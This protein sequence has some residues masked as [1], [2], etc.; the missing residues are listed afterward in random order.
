MQNLQLLLPTKV[1]LHTKL[2][3]REQ[4]VMHAMIHTCFY[5]WRWQTKLEL[6]MIHRCFHFILISNKGF[7]VHTAHKKNTHLL[8]RPWKGAM[9]PVAIHSSIHHSQPSQPEVGFS[10]LLL[11]DGCNASIH[12]KS[13][14][15]SCSSIGKIMHI[16][17][18]IGV[19]GRLLKVIHLCY[20]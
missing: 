19:F 3:L 20:A 18:I 2:I 8:Q 1:L 14:Q 13:K 6:E 9:P 15:L 16:S 17:Q 12:T 10:C 4:A 5:F 11:V 7:K